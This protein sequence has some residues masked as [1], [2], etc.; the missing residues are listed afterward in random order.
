LPY[1]A[2]YNPKRAF[3]GGY[4]FAKSSTALYEALNNVKNV[5]MSDAA[6]LNNMVEVDKNWDDYGLTEDEAKFL[7]RQTEEGTL[8]AAQFNALVGTARGKV[9]DN[10]AQAAI[11]AWMS[12]F[13]YTEQMN[14]RATALAAYRL[15]KERALSQ[16]ISEAQAITEATEAARKAVNTSQG[17]YAM[18]NRP[19]MARGNVLQYVFVY[20]QFV[21]LTVQL[22]RN[23][24]PKSQ[25][26]MLGFLLLAGGIKGLPF[27]EDIFD[28]VDTIA[29]KLGLKMA[30][31]E[32]E[33]A[34]WVDSVAPGMT[35]YVMRGVLDQ[36]TGSTISSRMGMGDLIPL[37]GA[38]R[39]G[40]DP[41]REVAD[42]AGPVFSGIAGLVG[43][44]GSLAKYGAEVIGLRDDT[45]SFNTIL[46]ESPVAA[47]RAVG[48][49]LAYTQSGMITNVRGQV[50]AKEAGAHTII[51]RLLGFYP[52]IATQQNDIVR[53]SKYVSEYNKA[54]KADYVGAYVKAKMAG[55]TD[56][57]QELSATVREWNEDAKGT[58][59]EVKNFEKSAN[60]AALEAGRPTALRYLKSAPKQMRP[61]TIELLK[62]HGIYDEIN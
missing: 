14:R 49:S 61:E 38:F 53:L 3:G 62:A 5:K 16:G 8:Q 34:M 10:R 45:T 43:T 25:M 21:L 46:R 24:P 32:K 19:E 36:M 13:S 48:D 47:M 44:A 33:I 52:A 57:M 23:L 20:K 40:A 51:A 35:P 42:F 39:A 7:F 31:I 6:W 2:S 56:R 15:E 4:G 12:M 1:L 37:T 59:L 50:V 22:L 27:A 17:E 41:A 58:G 30:S 29:Q 11:K 54:I 18:F 9:F 28:I 55:D 26:L 60:R